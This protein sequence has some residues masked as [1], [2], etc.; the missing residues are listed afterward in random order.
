MP[1]KYKCSLFIDQMSKNLL[2]NI[3][4]CHEHAYK[5]PNYF[6]YISSTIILKNSEFDIKSSDF[7]NFILIL[8]D[9]TSFGNFGNREK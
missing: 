4:L 6:E 3:V 2:K 7:Y 1:A 5:L 8:C 9:I